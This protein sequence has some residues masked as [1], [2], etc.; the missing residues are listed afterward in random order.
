MR[1]GR[2]GM[3]Q[4]HGARTRLCIADKVRGISTKQNTHLFL[5]SA[6]SLCQLS[7]P[8][9]VCPE[10]PRACALSTAMSL[11]KKHEYVFP[12][13]GSLLNCRGKKTVK[14]KLV[15]PKYLETEWTPLSS[16]LFL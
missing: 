8:T 9:H 15:K 2:A 12:I 14:G 13:P 7:I 1:Q 11:I 5:F 4:S 3:L 6:L 16:S 10:E